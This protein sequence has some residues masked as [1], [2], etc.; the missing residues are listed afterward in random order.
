MRPSTKMRHARGIF[1]SV[2]TGSAAVYRGPSETS[3]MVSMEVDAS[4]QRAMIEQRSTPGGLDTNQF[5]CIR[6]Q[7]V[8]VLKKNAVVLGS[9]EIRDAGFL[10]LGVGCDETTFVLHIQDDALV[11]RGAAPLHRKDPI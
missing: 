4:S 2:R 7:E 5:P 9:G 10:P 1:S 3:T 8:T 11:H 6:H